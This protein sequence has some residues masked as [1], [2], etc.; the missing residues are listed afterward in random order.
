MGRVLTIS[1]ELRGHPQRLRI[2]DSGHQ[3]VLTLSEKEPMKK[4]NPNDVSKDSR[5]SSYSMHPAAGLGLHWNV[6]DLNPTAQT[7]CKR[8]RQD[9]SRLIAT[10]G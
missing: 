10:A 1:N 6:E 2:C 7:K 9:I 8:M 4:F 3:L 5:H